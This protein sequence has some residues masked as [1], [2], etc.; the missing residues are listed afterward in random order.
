MKNKLQQLIKSN[1]GLITFIVLMAVFRGAIADWNV[2]PTGSM[3]PTIVE[4]DRIFVNKLAY[5]INLPFTTISL[6]ELDNPARGDIVVF[7]SEKAG[8]RLVKRVI[9]IPG[10]VVVLRDNKLMINGVSASYHSDLT[11]SKYSDDNYNDDGKAHESAVIVIESLLGY[12]HPIKLI[13][14]N[15]SPLQDFGPVTVPANH[16]L[17]LGDNRDN[18]ADSRVIGFVP[19]EEI[20]GKANRVIISLDYDRYYLPRTDRIL[21]PLL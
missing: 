7:N 14:R 6:I 12:S 8:K 5:D 2:V 21:T 9:A 15:H 4:G 18:S 20:I 1:R 16:Y 10:D 19:R 11:I 3:N 13:K 17:M